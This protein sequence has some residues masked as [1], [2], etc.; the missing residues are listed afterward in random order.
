[1]SVPRWIVPQHSIFLPGRN[2]RDS[3][4]KLPPIKEKMYYEPVEGSLHVAH[5]TNDARF[6]MR[7]LRS[8]AS[9]SL[10]EELVRLRSHICLDLSIFQRLGRAY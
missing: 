5:D 9:V 3:Y 1:M 6:Y 7:L 2:G 10:I 8:F 4:L